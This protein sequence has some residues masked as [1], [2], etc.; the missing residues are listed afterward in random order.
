MIDVEPQ[1]AV[2]L[3]SLTVPANLDYSAAIRD[4][5]LASLKNVGGFDAAWASR[6][7]LAVDELFMNAVRYGS[8]PGS[9]VH[10]QFDFAPH[11]LRVAVEDCGEG[12]CPL[13][14]RE[15]ATRVEAARKAHIAREQRGET[16]LALSGRGLSQLVSSW[17]DELSFEDSPAGG[18]RVTMTKTL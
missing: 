10:L 8:R 1:T 18:I 13:G 7:Q 17:A 4:F 11:R 2:G 15:L 14:A 16:N 12:A 5:T 9:P 6:M 3:V